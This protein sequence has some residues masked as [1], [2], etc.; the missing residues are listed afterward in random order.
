MIYQE[1]TPKFSNESRQNIRQLKVWGGRLWL[2]FTQKI[3]IITPLI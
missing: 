3:V 1:D 2:K